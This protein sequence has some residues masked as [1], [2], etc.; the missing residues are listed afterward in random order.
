MVW[1]YG[2]GSQCHPSL[3][4]KDDASLW[5]RGLQCPA[6]FAP[7]CNVTARPTDEVARFAASYLLLSQVNVRRSS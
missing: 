2:S 1:L 3:S 6:V 7:S 4:F 5:L